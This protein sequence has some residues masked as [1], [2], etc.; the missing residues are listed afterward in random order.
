MQCGFCTPGMIVAST[1]LLAANPAPDEA[2]IREAL[3]G[4]LCMCTGYVNIVRAVA[5]AAARAARSRRV[6]DDRRGL[7]RRRRCRS[8]RTR[9]WSPGA[10][11]SSTTSAARA[12]STRPCCAARTPTRASWRSTRARPRA[13]PGVLAVLTGAEAAARSGPIRPL[14][15]T[16]AAVPDYCLAVDRVRYVGR[17]GRGGGGGRPRHRRGRARA[18][19]AS[20]T[21]RC[22][23]WSTRS[24]RSRPDAPL[25]LSDELGTNVVWHDTLDL[26]RRRRR[27]GRAPT[28]CSR[29]RFTIQR[30]AST[31]LE[32]FGAIAEYDA[33]HRRVRVLDQRPAAG[34]TIGVAGRLARRPADRGSG[35]SLP[36]HRRRLRQQAPPGLSR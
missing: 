24:R 22:P 10:A 23:P 16:T 11:G 2:G 17:A 27:A 18:A 12:C 8:R 6:S 9:A 7:G 26:R 30:Y 14:I 35:S 13:L 15:P 5:Q 32:T 4:N 29:E 3:A 31:P 28:G 20:S 19:S 25:A 1:E 36:G 33:G 34:L 21:S